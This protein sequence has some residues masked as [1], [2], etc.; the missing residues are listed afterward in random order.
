MHAKEMYD[1]RMRPSM[2]ECELSTLVPD[3][4]GMTSGRVTA[5]SAG[6]LTRRGRVTAT[7]PSRII[8][9]QP[10]RPLSRLAPPAII[11][12]Y[13]PNSP[14]PSRPT[15]RGGVNYDSYVYHYRHASA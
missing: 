14:T 13:L 6:H 15:T 1:A 12:P 10:P 3:L 7:V 4:S 9:N 5:L 11:Q 8:I 2:P